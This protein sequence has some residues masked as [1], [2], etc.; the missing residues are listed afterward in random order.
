MR[1]VLNIA[2]SI[3]ALLGTVNAQIQEP[4][5]PCTMLSGICDP[6]NF[7]EYGTLS[8]LDEMARLDNVANQLQSEPKDFVVYLVAY[9][10]RRAC[11]GEAQARALRA[12]NYLVSKRSI[13][14]ERVI[15]ID[16]GYRERATT[17]VWIWTR[18]AGVPYASP[19]VD[20]S[21]AT[22]R[23]CK[24][25]PK[26]RRQRFNSPGAHNNRLQPTAR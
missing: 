24:P 19:T 12:K 14:P 26:S 25:R 15:W 11:V 1:Y 7:D 13:Q 2:I 10:G 17:E 18:R 9:A 8:R 16:G 5:A 22:L 20:Q 23:D 21:E 3:F 6:V 4:P